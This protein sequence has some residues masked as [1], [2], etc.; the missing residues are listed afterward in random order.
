MCIRDSVH[1]WHVRY[2][3]AMAAEP[4]SRVEWLLTELGP[5]L[6]RLRLTHRDLARSPLTWANV[7]DCLLYPSRCV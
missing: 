7:K 4:P 6:T 5:E 1:T 3:D 2:D